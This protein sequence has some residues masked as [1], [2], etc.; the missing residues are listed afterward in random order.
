MA[1]AFALIQ[2]LTS[3]KALKEQGKSIET[4]SEEEGKEWVNGQIEGMLVTL[5]AF[6]FEIK[7]KD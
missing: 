6:G 2:F 4:F 1:M 3:I 5:G 7:P